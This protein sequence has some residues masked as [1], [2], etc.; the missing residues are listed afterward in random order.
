MR[1][2][3]FIPLFIILASLFIFVWWKD[4]SSPPDPKDSKPRAFVVTRGQGANSIAQKLAKEGLIKSDL[5]LRTYLE[6]RGKTDKIQAGE[7]RLAPNLTLQQVVAALLLG[8]QELWVTFPEGFRREEMA[9]KTISTLGMEEDRAKAF[10]TEFL[11][12]TEGQEGFLFPDTYLFPRDV[13][14]K[15]VASKLRST[16]D[17]R[18]TEGM[19]S[20]AQEQG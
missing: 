11:D 12:E 17:L 2:L 14:A 7:Y 20:K 10:W 1:K 4:A 8:P 13:L 9:A 3:L 6:L 18:V 16:F 19:V 5:A 15:T